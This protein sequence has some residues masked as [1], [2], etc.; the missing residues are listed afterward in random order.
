ML[1][2]VNEGKI[3]FVVSVQK[4]LTERGWNAGQIAKEFATIIQG[5]GGGRPD[6]AQG[7]GKDVDALDKALAEVEPILKR[8][9]VKTPHK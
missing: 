5:S 7:G 9:I 3:S 2:S 8:L 1:A 6:F 4:T